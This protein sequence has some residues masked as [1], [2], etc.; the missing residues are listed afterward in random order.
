MSL[1]QYDDAN[2]CFATVFAIVYNALLSSMAVRK[3]ILKPRTLMVFTMNVIMVA[4]DAEA[5]KNGDFSGL[6][7]SI[8]VK[9]DIKY[10]SDYANGRRNLSKECI[11]LWDK[12]NYKGVTY[13][14]QTPETYG[15]LLYDLLEEIDRKDLI[16]N[17]KEVV[18][19]DTVLSNQEKG[20]QKALLKLLDEKGAADFLY[21]CVNEVIHYKNNRFNVP[22]K[23][24]TAQQKQAIKRRG[25][26]S[27]EEIELSTIFH[28]TYP[29]D[30]STNGANVSP[31]I[32]EESE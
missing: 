30:I 28:N 32:L 7:F 31:G 16:I 5:C 21:Y 24:L 2:L 19:H 26:I 6:P 29:D 20:K 18:V 8:E 23:I 3:K 27:P 15:V 17:L 11:K 9:N 25:G 12:K 14:V 22:T 1:K 4:I 13:Q 10:T